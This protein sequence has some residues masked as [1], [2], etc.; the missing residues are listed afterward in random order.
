MS[1]RPPKVGHV[2]RAPGGGAAET[3]RCHWPGCERRVKPALWGCREH[4]FALPP[5]IRTAIWRAYEPGQ[6]VSKRPS[7]AYLEAARAAQEWIAAQPRPGEDQG[8]GALL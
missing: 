6:E 2:L 1:V 7:R 4:W 5:A 3:H 8:Q